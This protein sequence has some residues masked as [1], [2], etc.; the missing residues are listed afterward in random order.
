MRFSGSRDEGS[1]DDSMSGEVSA[2]E[3]ERGLMGQSHRLD[4]P[5]LTVW[6]L[7]RCTRTR[8]SRG[9]RDLMFLKVADYQ[10]DERGEGKDGAEGGGCE[11]GRFLRRHRQARVS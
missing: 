9:T 8:S 11:L 4:E 1:G 3:L 7:N 10:D 5:G 2:S 6:G